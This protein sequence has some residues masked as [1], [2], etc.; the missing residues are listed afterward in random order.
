MPEHPWRV[1]KPSPIHPWGAAITVGGIIMAE[2][3]SEY[4]DEAARCVNAHDALVA[5]LEDLMVVSDEL[6]AL[7]EKHK[8]RGAFNR[9]RAAL[10][11]AKGEE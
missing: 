9:A 3:A 8:W 6:D 7:F 11:A 2:M 10:R 5:A 4:A 1:V